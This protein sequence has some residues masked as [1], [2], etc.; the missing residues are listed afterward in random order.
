MRGIMREL[1][2]VVVVGFGLAELGLEQERVASGDVIVEC[3][4]VD[5]FDRLVIGLADRHVALLETLGSANKR[6]P[7]AA[8]G[9]K[10]HAR[11][12]NVDSLLGNHDL[13]RDEQARAPDLVLV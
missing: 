7:P 4:S 6:N 2:S 10:S 8:D 3:K 5:N 9:L 11:N 13:C 1:R 12:P